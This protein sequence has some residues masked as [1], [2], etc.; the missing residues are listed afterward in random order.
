[1]VCAE[2]NV[3]SQTAVP[4]ANP[5]TS[6]WVNTLFD[7]PILR[8]LKPL[9][10]KLEGVAPPDVPEASIPAAQLP[11][12]TI[13]PIP[14]ITDPEALQFESKAD[15]AAVVDTE[16]MK[17]GASRALSKLVSLVSKVGG[18]VELKSAYRP[19]AYQAHLQAV[20]DKWK[21]VQDNSQPQCQDFRAAVQQEF[22]RHHL[23]ET[24]RP[25]NSSDHTRGLAF[26]ALVLLPQKAR[27]LKRRVTL[28]YL[29]RISG[30]RRVDILHDPV[31]FKF[32]GGTSRRA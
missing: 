24:Q 7:L 13:A 25:V 18:T 31:H 2:S 19:P 26:D 5:Q 9:I 12:C 28:D 1:L 22:T 30:V 10:N 15:S 6:S 29:A 11:P 23:I 27:L 8:L 14:P 21:E 3:P 32:I 16:D 17:P 20:W 4:A